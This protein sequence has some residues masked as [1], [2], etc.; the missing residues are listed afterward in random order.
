MI[1]DLAEKAGGCA[2]VAKADVVSRQG[3]GGYA[4]LRG[5]CYGRD[6]WCAIRPHTGG[7]GQQKGSTA[8]RGSVPS[9]RDLAGRRDNPSLELSSSEIMS[10]PGRILFRVSDDLNSNS[11]R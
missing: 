11:R 3:R 1:D 9:D 5:R 7:A 4:C 10:G 6:L 8:D 2:Q